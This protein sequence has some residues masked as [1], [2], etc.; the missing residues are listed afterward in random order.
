MPEI[1]VSHSSR[2]VEL[3]GRIVDLLETGA[4][5]SQGTI[6]ASS[7][8]GMGVPYGDFNAYIRER[9]KE[10][11]LALFVL[12]PNFERSAFCTAEMGAAWALGLNVMMFVTPGL[13]HA[14]VHGVFGGSYQVER[15]DDVASLDKL[16]DAAQSIGISAN[17][18]PVARWNAQTKAFRDW[19]GAAYQEAPRTSRPE[20][21]PGWRDRGHW[22]ATLVD[23]TLYT[24]GSTNI[25]VR[26]Q[27]LSEIERGRLPSTVFS[28]ITNSGFHNWIQ[29]THDPGYEYFAHSLGYF[30][31]SSGRIANDIVSATR[32][33]EVDFISLGPGDGQKDLMLLR[34]L[35]DC[36]TEISQLYYYP[37]DINPS[38]ISTAIRLIGTEPRLTPIKVKAILADFDSLPQFA[39]IYHYRNAPNV[40]S[41]L[42]NTLGNFADEQ[43]VLERIY[44]RAMSSGDLLLL[45][46]RAEE[47]GVGADIGRELSKRFNFGALEI[48]S[49]P[50]DPAHME[51]VEPSRARSTIPGTRTSLAR[52]DAVEIDGRT[53]ANV[54]L[55][56]INRYDPEEL[57]RVCRE[58]GFRVLDG[59]DVEHSVVA[60]LL[61]KP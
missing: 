47:A 36:A 25:D 41:L 49:I 39:P 2:D 28:Y 24:N 12:S 13:T 37:F 15:L 9:I 54:D 1:F 48:L 55:A 4:G 34:A 27:V 56:V 42:G 10:S 18:P 38:M 19:L 44:H 26:H 6:F 60:L 43:G 32:S 51:Y 35:A 16:R 46:V 21:M 17:P 7:L 3:V 57:T 40:L 11:Q 53:R 45:E 22:S 52:Y 8:A 33:G 5:V 14:D 50:F 58:I 29:L 30:R 61:Q 23:A 59:P 20:D 31:A